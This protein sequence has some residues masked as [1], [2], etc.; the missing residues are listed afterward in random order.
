MLLDEIPEGS[1]KQILIIDDDCDIRESVQFILKKEGYLTALAA[2]GVEGLER[3]KQEPFDLIILDLSMPRM[4][5]QEFV[6]QMA[7]AKMKIPII[8]IT[9]QANPALTF[10]G[11]ATKYKP[12]DMLPKPFLPNELT[13]KVEKYIQ[14]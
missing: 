4:T 6:A 14:S 1:K 12:L 13:D 10:R 2:D 8:I 5:G 9:A 3:A 7:R 11:L